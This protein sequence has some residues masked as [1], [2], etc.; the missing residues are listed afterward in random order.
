MDNVACNDEVVPLLFKALLQGTAL[1]VEDAEIS[2]VGEIL[3]SFLAAS[4]NPA[5]TSVKSYFWM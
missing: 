1:D 3:G 5:E 4:R 2:D